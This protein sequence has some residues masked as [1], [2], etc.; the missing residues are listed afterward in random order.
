VVAS[1]LFLAR[2]GRKRKPL[3]GAPRD[4]VV[5]YLNEKGRKAKVAK[6]VTIKKCVAYT[7]ADV[8]KLSAK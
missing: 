5:A 8:K 7:D 3:V 2:K 1:P 4:D 6:M